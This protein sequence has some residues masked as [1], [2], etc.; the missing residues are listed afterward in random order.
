[1]SGLVPNSEVAGALGGT[2]MFP[3]MFI[4]GV[5]YSVYSMSPLVIPIAQ[6]NPVTI[7]QNLFT[8]I[9]LKGGTF[10]NVLPYL[11]LLTGFGIIL[12]ILANFFVYCVTTSIKS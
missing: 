5:F 2:I 11:I 9:I 12:F 1:M 6:L 8:I 7:G 3:L 10:S 4:S